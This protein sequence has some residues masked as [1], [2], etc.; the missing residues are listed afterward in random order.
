MV[1]LGLD[2][3][4]HGNWETTS[5]AAQPCPCRAL[6]DRMWFHCSGIY[7]TCAFRPPI[8]DAL[9]TVTHQ[10]GKV[11]TLVTQGFSGYGVSVW[12]DENILEIV[13]M[14]THQCE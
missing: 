4:G 2:Q 12:G 8:L 9:P 6:P 11:G 5:T 10:L 14:A 3:Q 1:S 13:M 7:G